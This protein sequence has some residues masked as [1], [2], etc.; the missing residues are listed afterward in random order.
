MVRLNMDSLPERKFVRIDA[1]IHFI[2]QD[3][4]QMDIAGR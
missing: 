4:D 3:V 1:L 2:K